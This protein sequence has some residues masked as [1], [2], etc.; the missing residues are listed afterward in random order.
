MFNNPSIQS[1]I[2]KFNGNQFSWL[3]GFGIY[4]SLNT[5]YYYA[6]DWDANELFILNDEWKLLS[7]KSF[8][9]PAYMISINNSLYITG[10]HNVSKVDQDLNILIKYNPGG[11]PNYGGISY[12]PSNG[13][14]YVVANQFNEYQVF[15]LDL[16][17]IRRFSTSPHRPW[18]ITESSNQLY[19]G[20]YDSGVILVYR[21]ETIINQFN[22]CDGNSVTLTSILL[23]PNDYMA[24]SCSHPTNKLHIFSPNGSFTGKSLTTPAGPSYIGFDSKG[25]FIQI[26]AREIRIYL[27]LKEKS[28]P[29]IDLFSSS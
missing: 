28:N 25:R 22:G 7:S 5:S 2:L 16:T 8:T 27:Q 21:N 19:V 4:S 3:S 9:H 15:N 18:S 26:S 20:T 1:T 17:L 23:D 29:Q 12:N 11:I 24:T 13:L 6:M 14:I 10:T